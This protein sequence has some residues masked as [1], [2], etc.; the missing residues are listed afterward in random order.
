MELQ[1]QAVHFLC[2]VLHTLCHYCGFTFIEMNAKR[3]LSGEREM[4]VWKISYVLEVPGLAVPVIS[5][6]RSWSITPGLLMSCT[7]CASAICSVT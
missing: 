4:P 5:A 2:T 1:L 7:G 6:L 3:R